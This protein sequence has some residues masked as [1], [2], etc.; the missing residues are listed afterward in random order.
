MLVVLLVAC[1][2]GGKPA[3]K[4]GLVDTAAPIGGIVPAKEI[5][6]QISDGEGTRVMRL[7]PSGKIV[8][9]GQATGAMTASGEIKNADGTLVAVLGPDG[10]VEIPTF[11]YLGFKID[12]AGTLLQDGQ[13]VAKFGANNTLET[14]LEQNVDKTVAVGDTTQ[15]RALMF[16]WA[17]IV[18]SANNMRRPEPLE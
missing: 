1:S 12:A 2:G 7:L 3:P 11:S 5:G 17:G 9:Q 14:K 15:R 6:L 4:S 10:T 18:M 13:P 16:M 8:V